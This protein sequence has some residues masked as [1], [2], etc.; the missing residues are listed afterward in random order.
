MY[1]NWVIYDKK[2][3]IQAIYIIKDNIIPVGNPYIITLNK[4][5]VNKMVRMSL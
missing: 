3:Y 4:T 5:I 1:F 2:L